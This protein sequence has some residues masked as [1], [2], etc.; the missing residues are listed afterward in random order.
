MTGVSRRSSG[1]APRTLLTVGQIADT[2]DFDERSVRR[3]IKAG[4]LKAIR[5]GRRFRIRPDDFLE[6]LEENESR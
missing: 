5:L 3:W 4:R 2:T 1:E 6:F